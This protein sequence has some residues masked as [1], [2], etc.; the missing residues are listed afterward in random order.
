MSDY[1]PAAAPEWRSLAPEFV[2][3]KTLA[4]LITYAVLTAIATV[5]T[6]V[7]AGWQWGVGVAVVLIAFFAWRIVKV[8]EWCRTYRFALRERDVLVA[9][10]LLSRTLVSIPY[11]RIQT[12]SVEDGIIDRKWGLANVTVN[13]A[14]SQDGTIPGLPADEAA[15]LREEL[16]Q[17]G[18]THAIAL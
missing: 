13:T 5:P 6:W 1:F 8:R 11:G 15:A 9:S 14:S 12:V 10:G 17:L 16:I 4:R 3:V 18:V 7:F 2:A